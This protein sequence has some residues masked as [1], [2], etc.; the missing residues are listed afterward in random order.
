M[1]RYFIKRLLLFIPTLFLVSFLTFF[2]SKQVP[3]DQVEI[4]LNIQGVLDSDDYYGKSYEDL[5]KKMNLHLPEFYFS[6]RPN[7]KLS[8]HSLNSDLIEARFVE[9]ISSLKYS[10]NYVERL[11]TSIKSFDDINR[12]RLLFS[13]DLQ[14]LRDKLSALSIQDEKLKV[15]LLQQIDSAEKFKVQWH[16]PVLSYNGF[17]NQYHLWL[18]NALR[19]EFGVSLL[20]TRPVTNK[21]WDAMKWSLVLVFLN[22]VF[23]LL[24][25]FPIGV[26]NGVNPNS[27]FDN[28][29]N[30]ILFAFFAIPKFW[31]ATLMI[32]FF[33][34]I[35][36]GTWTNIFPSVGL[37]SNQGNQ[38]FFSMLGD[39][40][41]KLI[42]PVLI[43][44]IPD[45]AYLGRLI[46]SNVKEESQKEYVKTA[47][48]KG[49][50][51]RKI[52]LRHILPNSLIPTITLLVGTLPGAISS[53]LVIEVIFNI[54]GVGRLMYDSIMNADWAM[55]YPIVLIISVFAVVLFLLGD[56][57]MAILNPKIKLG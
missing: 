51:K 41:Q 15:D 52:T 43:L 22:L 8:S 54:P 18:V 13:N 56:I 47:M 30:S 25:S 38:S 55:V 12:R 53:A 26:Y 50:S 2:L 32:I 37:W 24:L 44:V 45:V 35:E 36:Y 1:V 5:H 28:I 19:G 31:L 21:L 42:L 39:N 34:T 23:A 6:V 14:Q 16:Y 49:L 57:V 27:K 46:R 10:K 40:W 48:S 29:S 20:D 17:E 33:T 4:L 7:Y 9:K 3:A 11:V